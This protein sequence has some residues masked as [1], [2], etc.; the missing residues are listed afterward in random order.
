MY[1]LSSPR[2]PSVSPPLV[3]DPRVVHHLHGLD[4][5]PY[6]L[7][8]SPLLTPNH[9]EIDS[10]RFSYDLDLG[11]VYELLIP[12]EVWGGRRGVEFVGW[13]DGEVMP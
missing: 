3:N 4:L 9:G 8:G 13:E 7:K 2:F 11:D 12:N 1:G 6:V 10:A 5:F